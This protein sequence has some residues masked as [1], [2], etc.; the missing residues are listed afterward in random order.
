MTQAPPLTNRLMAIGL[1]R[2][3]FITAA[4]QPANTKLIIDSDRLEQY[5][6]IRDEVVTGI[7]NITKE[8]DFEPEWVAGIPTGAT[9]LATWVCHELGVEYQPVFTKDKTGNLD[10]A[11]QLDEEMIQDL[12]DGLVVDDVA[13]A[14]SSIRKM[15]TL[16]GMFQRTKAF[17]P[18]F[19]RFDGDFR[20]GLPVQYHPLCTQPIPLLQADAG[21]GLS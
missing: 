17:I 13:T 3:D 5:P 11:T 9:K 20:G 10:F 2:G 21:K 6:D 18:V 7:A 15:L 12:G 1:E 19:D 14:W 16:P 8:L 4:G